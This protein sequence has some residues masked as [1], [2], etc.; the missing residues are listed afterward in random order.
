VAEAL[1]ALATIHV[2]EGK[3]I[4]AG[5]VFDPSD[6]PEKVRPDKGEINRLLD[7]GVLEE[8]DEPLSQDAFRDI[9][10]GPTAN[11]E[12]GR[13]LTLPRGGSIVT[14]PAEPK[15]VVGTEGELKGPSAGKKP[16]DPRNSPT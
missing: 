4:V 12:R 5:T 13:P 8:S 11:P 6:L 2:G 1:K 10:T 14:A 7:R 9:P 16:N 3:A 15:S